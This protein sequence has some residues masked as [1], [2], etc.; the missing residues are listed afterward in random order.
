MAASSTPSSTRTV[1]V[2]VPS[3]IDATGSRD[4]SAEL[5]AFVASVPDG[6][7]I[8]FPAGGV[9]RMD[10]GLVMDGRHELGL[11]GNGATLVSN[12]S[13]DCGRDC[14]L[15]YLKGGSSGIDI[16]DFEL[17]GNSP[18]PG[19]FDYQWEHAAAITVIGGS[20]V[21]IVGVT[22]TGVGGDALTLSGLAPDWPDGVVFRDSHVVTAGRMGVGI[23]AGRNVTIERVAFDRVG[24]GVF[25]IE[26]NEESQGAEHVRFAHNTAGSWS[27][28]LGFFAAA[29]GAEGTAVSGVT[30]T[31][32][33]ITDKPLVTFVDT[34]RR[35]DVTFTD[36]A[37]KVS[38]WGP[39][40][41]F[42]HVD[43]LT[44]SGNVQPMLIG[45]FATITDC[46]SV[47]Y[48]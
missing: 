22:V 28:R 19:S 46:T 41:T 31:G 27:A 33:T 17:V 39:V 24:Y 37:S 3:S 2:E 30:I 40:L 42:A 32:N 15:I 14:S 18:S 4:V 36:N 6:T 7:T 5:V 23:V 10:V 35:Q 21:E 16:R 25:D 29:N 34:P 20:D 48:R 9:Y 38:A 8:E 1:R 11:E 44:I 12:G 43:G 26:P 45:D 13:S 47:D